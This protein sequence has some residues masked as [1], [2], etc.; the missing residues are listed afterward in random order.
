MNIEAKYKGEDI[1][2]LL[3]QRAPILMVDVIYSIENDICEAGLTISANNMFVVDGKLTEPGLI[4]HIAQ[5]A[6]AF[7]S[8]RVNGVNA[9]PVL[10]YIGEV[11]KFSL[12]GLLPKVDDKV[13]TTI[14]IQ[15]EVMN[16]TMFI[17]ET[18]VNGALVAICQMKL[19]V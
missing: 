8:Y 6:S 13:V 7:V 15:S 18:R 4:E 10:G 11:K 2:K 1:K 5:S 3:N 12:L 9:S 16:I 17:S 19:S 14:K